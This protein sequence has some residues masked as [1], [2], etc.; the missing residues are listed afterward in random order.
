WATDHLGIAMWI[1]QRLWFGAI[2][3]TAA[4]GVRWLLAKLDI[5]RSSVAF[6][7]ALLYMLSPYQLA[8]LGRTSVLLLPWAGL[9]WLIG[10]AVDSGRKGTWRAPALFSLA[11]VTI[12]AVNASS[13]VYVGLGPLLW[14]PFAVWVTREITW[15]QAVGA[16]LRLGACTIPVQLWWIAGLRTQAAYGL[17]ILQLT[18]SLSTVAETASAAELL[19]G[20]GYWYFYGRDG[21]AVWTDS[22]RWYTQRLWLILVSFSLPALALLGAMVTRW[23]YRTYFILLVLTGLILGIGA[24]PY[25]DPSPF[26]AGVKAASQAGSAA[27]ALRNTPRAVPLLALGLAVLLAGALVAVG[28]WLLARRWGWAR[29]VAIAAVGLLAVLNFPPMWTGKLVQPQLE[30]P[31]ALP[32]YWT[33]AAS[34]LE[35]QGH[36]TRVLELPGQDFGAYRWGYTQD[37]ITRGL[38][39]R[40]W[41]GREL[42]PFGSP[43][44]ADLL[45][46]LDHRMQE[47]IYDPASLEPIARLM[48]VGS[49]L[50]RTDTQYERF[51]TPR[52]RTL[53][54]WLLD[55]ASDL[56]AITGYGTP[57]VNHAIASQPLMDETELGTKPTAAWPPPVA[58]AQITNPTN[59]VRAEPISRPLVVAGDGEGLVD[60]AEAGLLPAGQTIRYAA[61]FAADP[62]ALDALVSDGADLLLTDTNRRRAQRWGTLRENFGYTEQA[63]EKPLVTDPKD[64]RLA[65][66]P[67]ATDDSRSVADLVPVAAPAIAQVR[68]SSYGNP[69]S[70]TAED[71]PANAVDDDL[72]TAWRTGAFDEVRGEHLDIALAQPVTTDSVGLWQVQGGVNNRWITKVTLSFDGGHSQTVALGPESRTVTGQVLRFPKQ[73]FTTLR[74]TVDDANIPKLPSYPGISPVGLARVDIAGATV[75]QQVRLPTDLLRIPSAAAAT[76]QLTVELSRLRANPAEPFRSD[77]EPQLTRAFDLPAARTFAVNGQVRVDPRQPDAQLGSTLGDD[78]D[79]L[80]VASSDRL[81]GSLD[82]GARSAIDGDPSTFWS[83]GFLDQ[84]GRWLELTSPTAVATDHLDLV[85]VADGRHSVPTKLTLTADDG[86]AV[87]VAVPPVVD[88]TDENHTVTVRVATPALSF[89]KLRVTVAEVRP[90]TTIDF[91]SAAHVQMPVGIAE[92]GIA[93]LR[94]AAAPSEVRVCDRQLLLVDGQSVGACAIGSRADAVAG[95]PLRLTDSAGQPLTLALAPG[96]HVIEQVRAATTA[97][98]LDRVV[99]TAAAVGGPPAKAAAAPPPVVKVTAEGLHSYKLSVSGATQPFWLVLG[100]SQSDGWK[101]KVNGHS[102]GGSTL[103]DGYA[104]GW[105]VDP[106]GRTDLSVTVDWTPQRLVNIALV[107]SALAAL[108]CIAVAVVDPGRRRTDQAMAP[109]SPPVLR[110]FAGSG[111]ALALPRALAVAVSLGVIASVF[112]GWRP[113][114]AVALF[115]LATAAWS[116]SRRAL[117]L[118]PAALVGATAAMI[119]ALQWRRHYRPGVEWP[120]SFW[121]AHVVVLAAVLIVGADAIVQCI[122]RRPAQAKR[123]PRR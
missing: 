52:P 107:L 106:G 101:A 53:W 67:D 20:L 29:P 34:D 45:R 89:R 95:K 80:R 57:T 44:S 59:I 10:L 62:K 93:G 90:T 123:S 42:I 14:F 11:I 7:G 15:R 71:R 75:K 113:G 100:Q 8:Y 49:V 56:G 92:L 61:S 77:P 117:V 48:G 97:V 28:D 96:H 18:E 91:Y 13:L 43:A 120:R 109:A 104:N 26:G 74:I 99:L 72:A 25:A 98:D 55:P 119:T 122:R 73:T 40:S 32:S 38:L 39:N 23:R 76:N 27:F 69:V 6:V 37:L 84:A 114:L 68:A 36:D 115:A 47:G 105:M 4:M 85:V 22:V 12:G 58:V 86:P 54:S 2:L 108:V 116:P 31:E 66:F 103:I 118:V 21:A 64:S 9:P 16:L 1:S 88:G 110:H 41:V 3:F 46:A 60:A 87:T 111:T 112:G 102:I 30:R 35:A 63:G 121:P 70:Y 50:L 94:S 79:G 78:T 17:P 33:K 5:A 82:Q 65:E 19:R 83:P 81:S 51:R 24:H